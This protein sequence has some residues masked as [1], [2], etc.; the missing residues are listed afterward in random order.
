MRFVLAAACLLVTTVAVALATQASIDEPAKEQ[1]AGDE[2]AAARPT[3]RWGENYFPDV[4]LTTHEGKR[5]HFYRDLLQDKV[6]AINFMFTSCGNVC[7]AETARLKQVHALLGDRV[8]EDI[9]MYSITVD[10]EVDHPEVLADYRERFGIGEGWTF[11]RASPE[12]TDLIQRKLGLLVEK[13]DDPNDHNASLVLGNERTGRWTKR[14]PYDNP[15]QLAHLLAESMHNWAKGPRKGRKLASYAAAPSRANWETGERIFRT[16][17]AACHSMGEGSGLGPDLAGVTESR[18]QDWL[19]R[20]IME[21]D[22]L[23]DEGDATAVA[24]LHEWND[25]RM[26]NLGLDEK[27]ARAVI[28]FM[29]SWQ[30]GEKQARAGGLESAHAGHDVHPSEGHTRAHSGHEHAGH[31]HH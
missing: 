26:P 1:L 15:Q 3:R 30:G 20:W 21:P 8:G 11:L 19:V 22:A 24:L 29:A 13:L 6:V 28:G 16:R 31:Q 9:H 5:V 14:S 23:I 18:D 12:D 17:C 10:P 25:I 27:E 7:P 2:K 4:Y